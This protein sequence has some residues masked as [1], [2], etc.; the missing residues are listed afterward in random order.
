M[1]IT[2]KIRPKDGKSHHEEAAGGDTTEHPSPGVQ[3]TEPR[4][5]KTQGKHDEEQREHLQNNVSGPAPQAQHNPASTG[6][7]HATGSYTDNPK[8]GSGKQE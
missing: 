3:S 8:T 6:G 5:A 1:T 4:S 7:L 2:S